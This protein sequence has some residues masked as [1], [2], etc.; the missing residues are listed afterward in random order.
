MSD[1]LK[2]ATK[3]VAG[4]TSTRSK[5]PEGLFGGPDGPSHMTR[6]SG[7]RVETDDGVTLLDWTMALG[8]VSL[9]YGHPTVTEAAIRAARDGAI[10]PLPPTLEVRVAERLVAAYPGAEQARFFKTGAEAVAAAVRVARS[11]TDRTRVVHCGYHGWL[12]GPTAGIGVP[13]EVATLWRSVPFDDIGALEQAVREWEPAAL[14]LE[15]F[16]EHAPSREWIEAARRIA[17]EAGVALIFDEVKTAFRL[18][19]GGAAEVWG[20]APDLAVVGKA[21]AN[22]YPLAALLGRR[23]LM[24][25]LKQTW[26]SSTLSTEFVSLAAADAVLDVWEKEDVAMHIQGIGIAMLEGLAGLTN[27]DCELHGAPAMWF[28]KFSDAAREHRFLLGCVKR[29]VLMKRGAYN[30]PCLA[31]GDDEVRVTLDA[32]RDALAESAA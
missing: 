22:G 21:L 9:G 5:A 4:I 16:I 7:C 3:A 27:P 30:F 24:A 11:V 23:E 20:V 28:L 1:W 14:V 8:A 25:R 18:R 29:G 15:P 2:R 6:A 12:D 31:H 26:V 19:R 17:D 13:G 32:V 10:G